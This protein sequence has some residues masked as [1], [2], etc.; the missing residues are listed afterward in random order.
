MSHRGPITTFSPIDASALENSVPNPTT[1]DRWQDA[2]TRH[3][4][5]V[6]KYCP[7]SPGIRESV[8]V[9]HSRD[10]SLPTRNARI[11]NDA[12]KGRTTIV[13]IPNATVLRPE[14]NVWHHSFD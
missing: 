14:R 3:K 9:L 8:C 7:V 5:A 6:R 4:K 10:R 1:T 11:L 2:S 12:S 13:A